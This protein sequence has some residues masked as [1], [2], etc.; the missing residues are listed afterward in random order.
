ML[1]AVLS[2]I[3]EEALRS[4]GFEFAAPVVLVS[5]FPLSTPSAVGFDIVGAIDA[6]FLMRSHLHL[7]MRFFRSPFMTACGILTKVAAN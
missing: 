1:T 2:Q 3:I 4:L 7:F 6:R 5:V